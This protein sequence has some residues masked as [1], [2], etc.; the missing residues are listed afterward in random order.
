[1]QKNPLQLVSAFIFICL[2]SFNLFAEKTDQTIQTPISSDGHYTVTIE[3]KI[4]PP[5]P[6]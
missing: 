2:F 6:W 3:S 1:M 4:K 5:S